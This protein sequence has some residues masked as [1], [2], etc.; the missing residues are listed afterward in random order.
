MSFIVARSFG[1]TGSEERLLDCPHSTII[2][3]PTN[4]RYQSTIPAGV[5]CQGNTSAPVECERGEVRL[6][7]GATQAEGRVEI[8]ANGYWSVP[9]DYGSLWEEA[10]LICKRLNLPT[11]CECLLKEN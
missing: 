10:R 2:L 3:S 5:I 6:V 1:C 7:G 9:C 8:C 4:T 11:S